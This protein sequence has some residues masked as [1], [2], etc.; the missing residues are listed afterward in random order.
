MSHGL[1][2]PPFNLFLKQHYLTVFVLVEPVICCTRESCMQLVSAIPVR[3]IDPLGTPVII[4]ID[5]S[6]LE[7]IV[8]CH[9][10]LLKNDLNA[11]SDTSRDSRQ[12]IS[13]EWHIYFILF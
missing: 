10:F 3:N 4:S 9:L 2:N 6:L 7:K 1:S 11:A 12:I 13:C 5:I 8:L